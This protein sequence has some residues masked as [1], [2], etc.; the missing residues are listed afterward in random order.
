M[1][2]ALETWGLVH[3][4]H[5]KLQPGTYLEP[6]CQ[7]REVANVT[8]GRPPLSQASLRKLPRQV[9]TSKRDLPAD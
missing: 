9:D 8:S 3:G 4:R 7:P 1:P 5:P 2:L 6:C